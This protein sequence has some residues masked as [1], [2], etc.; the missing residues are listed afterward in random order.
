MFLRM[1]TAWAHIILMYSYNLADMWNS[2]K[3]T[4]YKQQL[5]ELFCIFAKKRKEYKI[6]NSPKCTHYIQSA[7]ERTV[8][9]FCKKEKRILI[10]LEIPQNVHIMQSAIERTV[11][12]FC[13]KREKNS[14]KIGNSAKCIHYTMCNFLFLQK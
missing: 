5:R 11:L 4:L 8:L 2:P 9:H 13:K 3:C 12:H 6:G 7:I 10:K 1:A 14:Y